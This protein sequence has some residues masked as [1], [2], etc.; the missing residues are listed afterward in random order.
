M[1]KSGQRIA[2]YGFI[3][4]T[5][6]ELLILQRAEHDSMPGTWEL[7]GGTSELGEDP[8]DAAK[9]EVFEETGLIVTIS[10][11]LGIL[12]VHS[13]RHPQTHIIR[14]AFL[15]KLGNDEQTVTLSDEHSH[16]RWVSLI[17]A[18]L[19]QSEF[20]Q[21]ILTEVQRYPSLLP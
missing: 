8:K 1:Q 19:N 16:F 7:P 17:E 3:F 12:S 18:I 5:K 20:L 14:I 6:R 2:S 15:C 10:Y 11:P 9:R 21:Y 13:R 4:N